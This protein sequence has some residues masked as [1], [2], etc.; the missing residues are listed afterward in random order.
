MSAARSV[1]DRLLELE[2]H[3]RA[4]DAFVIQVTRECHARLLE[5]EERLSTLQSLDGEQEAANSQH[6]DTPQSTPPA[7]RSPSRSAPRSPSRSAPRSP[8]PAPRTPLH[9]LDERVRTLLQAAGYETAEAVRA[10]PD[11]ALIAIEGIGPKSLTHIREAFG[12]M[13]DEG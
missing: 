8:L 4:L 11:E 6:N 12:R 10:A 2:E 3:L 7:S 13:K 1:A 9:E 5:L